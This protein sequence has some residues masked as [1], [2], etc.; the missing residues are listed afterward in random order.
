M[1]TNQYYCKRCEDFFKINPLAPVRC[2]ICFGS[3][4]LLGPY[5]VDELEYD[6]SDRRKII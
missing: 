3:D 6:P 4:M 2:P 1:K 5:L